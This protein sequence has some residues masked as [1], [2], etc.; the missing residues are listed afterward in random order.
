VDHPATPR[1]M[2]IGDCDN[3][4]SDCRW[5]IL[6]KPRASGTVRASPSQRALPRRSGAGRTN[7]WERLAGTGSLAAA[8]RGRL[9]CRHV[10]GYGETQPRTSKGSWPAPPRPEGRRPCRHGLPQSGRRARR[11][12]RP[13]ATSVGRILGRRLV[14]AS[15]YDSPIGLTAESAED[16]EMSHSPPRY[17][18]V[19]Y[20][21]AVSVAQRKPLHRLPLRSR[22]PRR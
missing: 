16:A 7:A 17:M 9:P 13:P 10:A 12:R 18:Q 4:R 2:P 15:S 20:S 1:P 6:S 11:R 22:R 3:P 8:A 5:A 19:S 14:R 21:Q